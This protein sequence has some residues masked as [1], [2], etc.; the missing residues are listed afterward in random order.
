MHPSAST[1]DLVSRQPGDLGGSKL[2]RTGHVIEEGNFV[3]AYPV[4]GVN[5]FQQGV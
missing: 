3:I 2:Q 1:A 5:H 4:I